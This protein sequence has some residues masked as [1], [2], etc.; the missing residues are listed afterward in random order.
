[1]FALILNA[2]QA[3]AHAES[4]VVA[5][6]DEYA[7]KTETPAAPVGDYG[8]VL[9]ETAAKQDASAEKAAKA[10]RK[11]FDRLLGQA[12][13]PKELSN[14]EQQTVD[15]VANVA[16]PWWSWP[17]GLLAFGVLLI[18][19]SK[20]NKQQIPLEAKVLTKGIMVPVTEVIN[21]PSSTKAFILGRPK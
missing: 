15:S 19:R 7:S 6:G 20:A 12:A 16:L 3:T 5:A 1:M 8:P 4:L 14:A 21:A 9:A 10:D 17:L 13:A 11:E 2:F 18:V